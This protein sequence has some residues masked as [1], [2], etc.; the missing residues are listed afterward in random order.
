MKI[1]FA[2]YHGAGND[3][4]LI[5]N[6]LRRFPK[7]D[8]TIATLC[9]RRYGVGAD[10][11]ILIENHPDFNFE[12]VYYN[13]DGGLGS[14][15]GNGGRCA[16]IF[17]KEAGLIGHGA[18]F[19]AYDGVHVANILDKGIVK[20]S[21]NTVK[22]ISM[23]GDAYVL[24]T[25]SPH[26]VE[27]VHSLA[28]TEVVTAG[29]KIRNSMAYLKEGINVNFAERK[30]DKWWMRTYERGV[31]DETLSCGTGTVAVAIAASLH[32]KNDE[33]EQVYSIHAPGGDLKV[34]FKK[35]SPEHFSNVYLEGPVVHVFDG[36][37]EI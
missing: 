7:D 29:R 1:S 25:G 9:H 14:M 23:N 4:I 2:K 21:M 24:D 35:E 31:E 15:C 8:H 20:L 11:L 28:E 13:A 10:G 27:F 30:G 37:L 5:D 36:A 12:M 26:Y 6:R 18:E 16:V 17:A 19:L 33:E 3:F 22:K 32:L 34:Y